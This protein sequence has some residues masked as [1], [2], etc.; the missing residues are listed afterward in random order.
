MVDSYGQLE[1]DHSS[2]GFLPA[3]FYAEI[4]T[5]LRLINADPNSKT[6]R[7]E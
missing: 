6:Y 2:I 7:N 3:T 1:A 5:V 4:D